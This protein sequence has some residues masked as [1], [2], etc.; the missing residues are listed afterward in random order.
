ML[1]EWGKLNSVE[2][3]RFQIPSPQPNDLSRVQPKLF[4][5]VQL[6]IGQTKYT[7]KHFLCHFKGGL[8]SGVRWV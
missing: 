7:L 4:D 3:L 1:S 5:A 8:F 6:L 2:K